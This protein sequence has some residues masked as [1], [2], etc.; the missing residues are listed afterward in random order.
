MQQRVGLARAIT[1]DPEVILM[2]EPFSALDPLIRRQLQDEFRQLTKELGKSAVFITHDLDEAIR[3][4][5]RIAIMK[6]GVI[7]QVGT[8]EEIVLNP[9]DDYVAE[10]V[11]GISRLHLVKAQSVM[12]PVEPFKVAN[13]GCDIARLTKTTPE[14]DINEL[15]GLTM[16]SERDALAVVDNDTVVGIIT[17]RDLLRGV[18]GI[19][20]E[21]AAAPAV[22]VLEA[23]T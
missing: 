20:N 10:F 8:A 7:I 12:T 21:F 1:A 17:I 16:K 3:I 19:P 23:S 13:P 11:A 14:A 6:D 9:A 4:G 15:I 5:D 2:D 22:N 18:Q